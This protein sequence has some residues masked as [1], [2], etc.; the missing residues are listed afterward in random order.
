MLPVSIA[1]E[2]DPTDALKMPQLMCESE[3]YVE[4]KLEDFVTLLSRNNWSE[5][6]HP[7]S[8]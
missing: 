8:W 7:H 3:T 5:E 1:Y 6:T 4:K 2:Y